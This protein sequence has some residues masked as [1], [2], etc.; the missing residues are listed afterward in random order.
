MRH[1]AP[2]R[3][4]LTL[5]TNCVIDVE[6][7]EGAVLELRRLLSKHQTGQI[8]L[9]LAGI[10][11]SERLRAGGYASNMSEFADRVQRLSSRAIRVL[12]PIGRWGVTY[13]DGGVWADDS[14]TNL[15][16]TIH[17][18]LFAQS[19]EWAVIARANGIDPAAAPDE[20]DTDWR[21]WRNRLCDSAAMW[22][23][24]H[25]GGDMFVTR[26]ENF[27]KPVKRTAL[28]QLG[29]RRIGDPTD[30]CNYVGA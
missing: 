8:E 18:I 6:S 26:D 7:G 14:M 21:K 17:G 15:E 12:E 1:V 27:L 3:M 23:H 30:A 13:W 19:Y 25:Y 5:D 29:A 16:R 22:C 20:S 2:T 10:M 9:Q 4:T 11:A 24:I 28:E